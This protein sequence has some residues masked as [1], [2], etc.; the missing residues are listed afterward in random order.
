MQEAG[1]KS[2]TCRRAFFVAQRMPNFLQA[3]LVFGVHLNEGE[4]SE[5][6]ARSETAQMRTK[7][8]R[9][10]LVAAC[11]LRQGVCILRISKQL[12]AIFVEEG[13]LSGKGT[14]LLIFGGQVARGY[15]A[16]F[17]I[18]LV[19]SINSDDGSRDGR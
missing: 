4:Q 19:D 5:I 16:G 10:R 11:S 14:G 12:D 7:I 8:T 13:F 3:R 18:G 6:I 15:L 9:E 2:Q 17:G 1:T